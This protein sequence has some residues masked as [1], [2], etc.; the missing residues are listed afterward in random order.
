MAN[1]L[2]SMVKVFKTKRVPKTQRVP[3]P[4]PALLQ[5]PLM[6]AV[7]TL[8]ADSAFSDNKMLDIIKVFMA[9]HTFAAVYATL[10]TS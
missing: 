1:S 5:D 2:A 7:V 9:N 4:P 10:Q 6:R 8:E 3:T